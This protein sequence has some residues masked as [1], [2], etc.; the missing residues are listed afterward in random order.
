MHI[1][2]KKLFYSLLQYLNQMIYSDLRS[3]KKM[4]N[5]SFNCRELENSHIDFAI[6]LIEIE[7]YFLMTAHF[8]AI[9]SQM[10]QF[11]LK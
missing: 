5:L 2:L 6:N 11:I 9:H 10:M 7:F 4:D 8:Q 1:H 3:F